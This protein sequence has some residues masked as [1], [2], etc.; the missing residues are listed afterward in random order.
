MG[1]EY[2]NSPQRFGSKDLSRAEARDAADIKLSIKEGQADLMGRYEEVRE[3]IADNLHRESPQEIID[4]LTTASEMPTQHSIPHI[5]RL[6]SSIVFRTDLQ[7]TPDPELV[8]AHILEKIQ[9]HL[10]FFLEGVLEIGLITLSTNGLFQNRLYELLM[11]PFYT[12]SQV[13]NH[14]GTVKKEFP[15]I[16]DTLA[17]VAPEKLQRISY[18]ILKLAS[19]AETMIVGYP[20]TYVDDQGNFGEWIIDL[21]G[22]NFL[23]RYPEGRVNPN[24]S[25]DHK[26]ISKLLKATKGIYEE[27]NK[28]EER[29]SRFEPDLIP[30]LH[31][32]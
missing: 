2:S 14:D 30:H 23:D 25:L 22:E 21:A 1:S 3:K 18:L 20:N 13:K 11:E 31:L 9:D 24:Q 15:P 32:L 26:Y 7:M 8:Q 5:R 29:Y 10:I 16:W 28:P 27:K 19:A 12:V 17:D 6:L 4:V